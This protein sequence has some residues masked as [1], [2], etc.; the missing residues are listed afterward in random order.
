[1]EKAAE[2]NSCDCN[3]RIVAQTPHYLVLDKPAML[4][5][6]KLPRGGGVALADALLDFDPS[7]AKVGDK[8]GDAGLLQRL[9]Y[10]TSGLIVAART[11]AA[12]QKLRKSLLSKEWEK[13]YFILVEGQF[14]NQA[15]CDLALG[16]SNRNAKIVRAYKVPR[17][18][19][20]AL[21][22]ITSFRLL[23]YDSA[24]NLSLVEA[25]AQS[26]R[27][28]QVRA[29]AACLG[30]PLLGDQ[31]YG[32]TRT[33]TDIGASASQQHSFILH[34]WR[35]S[36]KDPFSGATASYSL[37]APAV[38]FQISGLAQLARALPQLDL[39]QQH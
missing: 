16:N 7:L 19:D 18:R 28:H 39:P 36:F 32:A 37:S 4:H 13:S 20:R 27:R 34:A 5:S 14:P 24:L 2:R 33:L 23:A 11:P 9:D 29:H 22:A 38:L 25:R 30:H 6:V 10:E 1:M 17:K 3:L 21:P 26:A 35:I 31:L 15:I 8:E 12:W